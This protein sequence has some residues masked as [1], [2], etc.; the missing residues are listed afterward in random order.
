MAFKT[1]PL[2]ET[3]DKDRLMDLEPITWEAAGDDLRAWVLAEADR[4]KEAGQTQCPT[5]AAAATMELNGVSALR[6]TE[7]RMLGE[8]LCSHEAAGGLDSHFERLFELHPEGPTLD[9]Q[10]ALQALAW[11]LTLL[12][13]AAGLTE[14]DA[15][16]TPEPEPI[17]GETRWEA[18]KREMAVEWRALLRQEVDHTDHG[19]AEVFFGLPLF[20]PT[21][22]RFR[23]DLNGGRCYGPLG[24]LWWPYRYPGTWVR[25]LALEGIVALM[26]LG[27]VVAV[28]A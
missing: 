25:E 17:P 21:S 7:R 22:V 19:H 9:R 24:L 23:R 28:T 10:A 11:E 14:A 5:C 16:A 26:T 20:L 3:L 15:L 1:I 8:D 27:T 6:D 4:Q 2:L 18:F 13:K 12:C